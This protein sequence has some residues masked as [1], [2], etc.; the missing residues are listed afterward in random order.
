MSDQ[1]IDLFV[2]QSPTQSLDTGEGYFPEA[3]GVTLADGTILFTWRDDATQD[4][5]AGTGNF[6]PFLSFQNSTDEKGANFYNGATHGTGDA[7][8]AADNRT[9]LLKTEVVP[10]IT[11]DGIEYYEF[12]L[13][14]NETGGQKSL[15]S[16]E[17]FKIFGSNSAT[18]TGD[19]LDPLYSIDANGIN[20][21]INIWD[22]N[23]G[24]GRSDVVMLIPKSY[25]TS[26]PEYL[27]FEAKLSGTDAGFEEFSVYVL[28]QVDT[29]LVSITKDADVFNANATDDGVLTFKCPCLAY[30]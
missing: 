7:I 26:D 11:V 10:V 2:T 4:D 22:D 6:D 1:I 17:S 20:T 15:L 12:R 14:V 16:L 23:S 28:Q 8:I 27:Y 3:P 30:I 21:T 18:E 9:S 13:D 19:G 24:S 5:P 25:F 29:P